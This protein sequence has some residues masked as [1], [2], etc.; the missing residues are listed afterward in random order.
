MILYN[1]C[2]PLYV[3]LLPADSAIERVPTVQ[4]GCMRIV[5]YYLVNTSKY[6]ENK[7]NFFTSVTEKNDYLNG[8]FTQKQ[9]LTSLFKNL[10]S[11]FEVSA[12]QYILFLLSICPALLLGLLVSYV[13]CSQYLLSCAMGRALNLTSYFFTFSCLVCPLGADTSFNFALFHVAVSDVAFFLVWSVRLTVS[14]IASRVIC[15]FL[16][17]MTCPK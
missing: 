10:F 2:T 11:C 14:C 4:I 12:R 6:F 9:R 8:C 15:H 3:F 17:L 5:W 7:Y 13:V 1:V 16:L